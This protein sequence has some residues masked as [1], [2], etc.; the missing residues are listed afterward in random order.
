MQE[1]YE[2]CINK[3]FSRDEVDKTIEEYE[4]LNVMQQNQA[5]TT[6]IFID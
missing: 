2:Q 1:V 4:R 6:L 3:G 5:R